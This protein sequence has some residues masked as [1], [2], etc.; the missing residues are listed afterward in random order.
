MLCLLIQLLGGVKNIYPW[1]Q[2]K[3]F[4]ALILLN[5]KNW[6]PQKVIGFISN[7]KFAPHFTQLW[8]CV[9]V[10]GPSR[11]GDLPELKQWHALYAFRLRKGTFWTWSVII[12]SSIHHNHR[13]Q[14]LDAFRKL[15]K[16]AAFP[17]FALTLAVPCLSGTLRLKVIAG[18]KHFPSSVMIW[19]WERKEGKKERKK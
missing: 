5:E 12:A 7:W 14:S 15:L 17:C 1:I 19:S 4:A 2:I 8:A 10:V 16:C 3:S 6:E 13:S 9:H 11:K 18:G